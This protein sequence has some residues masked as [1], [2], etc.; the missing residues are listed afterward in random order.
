M[1]IIFIFCSLI[2]AFVTCKPKQHIASAQQAHAAKD[3]SLFTSSGKISHMY[4]AGGCGAVIISDKNPQHDT[5]ILIPVPSLKEF[6]KVGLEI[7]F[8]YRIL[9]IHTPKGC[10]AGIPVQIM[11]I[12]EK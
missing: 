7:K 11:N 12:K 4:S 6:D 2:V 1:R 8:N 5:L 9:K 3:S 10:G